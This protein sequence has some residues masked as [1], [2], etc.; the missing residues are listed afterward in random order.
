[1]PRKSF[2]TLM[3]NGSWTFQGLGWKDN[4]SRSLQRAQNWLRDHLLSHCSLDSRESFLC[5]N[6]YAR[7]IAVTTERKK[8]EAHA[9]SFQ[10]Y[11]S[12][13]Q[14]V[15]TLIQLLHK[16]TDQKNQ[17]LIV[18]P[19]CGD[20]RI[21]KAIASTSSSFPSV[22]LVGVDIDP[23]MEDSVM[24]AAQTIPSSD[25]TKDSI[26]FL[27]MD[28]L[29]TNSDSFK[30]DTRNDEKE[31]LVVIGNPPF[32]DCAMRMDST[33]EEQREDYPLQFLLHSAVTLDADLI[34]FLLPRRCSRSEFI[35]N[36]LEQM[37]SSLSLSS[38]G[39]KWILAE[40]VSADSAFE[41]CGRIIQ[42]PV[43][44]MVWKKLIIS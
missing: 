4:L 19:S 2:K 20:G 28:F 16:Y 12:S 24:A 18:E 43:V 36:A 25:L 39:V 31:I 42:Q 7:R 44:I 6:Q 27:S 21:M 41:L 11:F 5:D 1:M 30:L 17:I 14:N 15:R 9:K 34:L 40:C 26:R 38:S 35:E 23:I 22:R 29:Q 37:N 32:S 10:Q 13:E 8:E 3:A 33:G